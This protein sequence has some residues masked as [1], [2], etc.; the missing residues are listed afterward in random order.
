MFCVGASVIGGSHVLSKRLNEDYL[1]EKKL[2]NGWHV[3]VVCDGCGSSKYAA[4]GAQLTGDLI[5]Q[6]LSDL[7]SS[8]KEQQLGD[9]IIDEVI[10]RFA[11]TRRT[12]RKT[13][14]TGN[15][16][17]YSATVVAALASEDGGFLVHIGDGIGTVFSVDYSLS[18]TPT[19]SQ[20]AASN[21]ENGEYSNQTWYL[22]DPK[23]IRHIRV[24]PFDKC[25]LCI[26]CTDGAQPLFYTGNNLEKTQLATL[27]NAIK[28]ENDRLL[29]NEL[30]SLLNSDAAARISDDDKTLAILMSSAAIS[31]LKSTVMPFVNET[32]SP[33]TA[34]SKVQSSAVANTQSLSK[35]R[36]Q[37]KSEDIT[38]LDKRPM[39]P[40]IV[41]KLHLVTLTIILLLI[42]NLVLI[43]YVFNV[44]PK[45]LFTSQQHGNAKPSTK[46]DARNSSIGS[47]Q[48]QEKEPLSNA[49]QKSLPAKKESDVETDT[50]SKNRAISKPPLNNAEKPKK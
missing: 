14:D 47:E 21:P 43:A 3:C 22:T 45:S 37:Q 46:D 7:A 33:H 35:F 12:L 11:R 17:D 36:A 16:S 41:R 34:N 26:L 50:Q 13:I 38:L 23:W 15:L 1:V 6:E 8:I 20:R 24:T 27:L 2:N 44:I 48:L 40:S 19:L 28:R 4:K 18:D 30:T 29:G 39:L 49:D 5:A 25:D 32:Q 10:E 9:W 42:S 31:L